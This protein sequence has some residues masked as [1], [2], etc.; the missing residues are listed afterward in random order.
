M[1]CY[2]HNLYKDEKKKISMHVTLCIC[3]KIF[4]A[5]KTM[6]TTLIP[7]KILVL[8]QKLPFLFKSQVIICI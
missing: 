4:F 5:M 7:L 8:L 3:M 6:K 1:C 2:T